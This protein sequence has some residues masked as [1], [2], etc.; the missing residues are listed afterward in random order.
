MI[1][2]WN[3]PFSGVLGAG[4]SSDLDLY[5]CPSDNPLT[6]QPSAGARDAQGCS[7][8]SGGPSGDPIEIL[9]VTNFRSGD[10]TFH[11]AVEHSCGNEDVRFRVISFALGCN[12]PS[13]Y[14]FDA[15]VFNKSQAYGHPVGD[16]VIGTA[17]TFYQEIDSEGAQEG[18]PAVVNVEAFSS[19]GGDIP[20]YFDR[21]GEPLPGGPALRT[22]PLIT[23]P[24]GTNTSFFGLRDAEGDGLLNFYG[25][26]AA[27]PHAAAVAALMLEANPTLSA[28]AILEDLRRTSIDIEAPGFDFLSGSGLIDALDAV[29]AAIARLTATP[30]FTPSATSTA[31]ATATP[32]PPT[33]TPT[34]FPT[35]D[36][37]PGDCDQNGTVS[38]DELV[39]G[40]RINLGSSE[41]AICTASDVDDDGDVTVSELVKAVNANLDA[42][43]CSEKA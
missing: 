28:E 35:G 21:D 24:D 5:A 36:N 7:S 20:I 23:A 31:S 16:G 8:G 26:S 25:T 6:C 4:A 18:D 34:P 13:R 27:A 2:Q 17:A 40:V 15:S 12:F 10:R 30:T 3:E 32:P 38:V 33:A 22:N 14:E 11:I 1:L 41:L 43:T 37:C 42:T 19:L 29:D 9:D 39:R